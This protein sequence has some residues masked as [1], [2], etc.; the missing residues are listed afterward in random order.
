MSD[1]LERLAA[2]ADL[3]RRVGVVYFAQPF[4]V[5]AAL[6]GLAGLLDDVAAELRA[7]ETDNERLREALRTIRDIRH[8]GSS[9]DMKYAASVA[10]EALAASGE[11]A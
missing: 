8:D 7:A 9:G 11:E 10:R 2:R 6:D 5:R 4:P 3:A 1:L